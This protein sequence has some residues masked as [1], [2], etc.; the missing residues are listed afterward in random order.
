MSITKND[1]STR[2]DIKL[3]VD[4][5]YNKVNEDEILSPIFNDFSKVN[6]ETHLP[7]MY[8][9]W[10]SILLAEG[11]YKGSPFLKHIPLPVDKTHFDRWIQLFNKNM[12]ELFE[13][14]MAN[15]TKLRAKSIAHIFQTK[16]EF[17]NKNRE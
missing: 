9:F 3:M 1:I 15:A 5:F 7:R 11:N 12:D 16:L 2:E 13:G 4:S 17:I 8:D 6:W 10:G 14:E